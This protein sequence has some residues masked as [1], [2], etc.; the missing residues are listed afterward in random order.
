MAFSK[1]MRID[2]KRPNLHLRQAFNWSGIG[3]DQITS[4]R[5][6]GRPTPNE[7]SDNSKFPG[8]LLMRIELTSVKRQIVE[9]LFGSRGRELFRSQMATSG[10]SEGFGRILRWRGRGDVFAR[11]VGK[12]VNL[13][14]ALLEIEFVTSGS[15][16]FTV[17]KETFQN[18]ISSFFSMLFND[19]ETMRIEFPKIAKLIVRVRQR[20]RSNLW[21]HD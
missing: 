14:W 16:M 7:Q 3:W 17:F 19:Y 1:R 2:K 13:R 11:L 18:E 8:K 9:L 12:D 10:W 15:T 5:F 20:G 4:D 21:I 6:I